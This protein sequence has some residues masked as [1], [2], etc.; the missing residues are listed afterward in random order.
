MKKIKLAKFINEDFSG[1]MGTPEVSEPK[2]DKKVFTES[3]KKFANYSE[4]LKSRGYKE[5]LKE[6]KFLVE[7]GSNL[8]VTETEEWFDKVTVGRHSKQLKEAYKTFE[9]AVQEAHVL[10]QRVL[11]AYEDIGQNLGKY[12]EV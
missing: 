4:V 8:M 11:A 12:Y 5:I 10:E 6:V 3:C 2:I 1:D 7:A 9:K